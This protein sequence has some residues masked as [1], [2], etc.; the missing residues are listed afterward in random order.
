MLDQC[1]CYEQFI[2]DNVITGTVGHGSHF[3]KKILMILW[4]VNKQRVA[5]TADCKCPSENG[6]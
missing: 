2:R 1:M 4:V 3:T 6:L 5:D